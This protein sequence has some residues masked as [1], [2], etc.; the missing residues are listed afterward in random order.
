MDLDP[1]DLLLIEVQFH[2]KPGA[3]IR[4][5]IAV[6]DSGDG[7][8][9]GVPLTSR[10]WGS[11]YDLALSDWEAAGLNVPSTARVHKIAVP[12]KT[13]IRHHRGRLSA[14]DLVSVRD[15]LRRA[16]SPHSK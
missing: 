8:F 5:A 11:D 12:S 13:S 3:K 14:R 9:V 1:G 16:F 6:L 4:P 2:Q 10:A 7:D 15:A